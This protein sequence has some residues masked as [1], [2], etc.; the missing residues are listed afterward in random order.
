MRSEK[1]SI[2]GSELINEHEVAK[3]AKLS[4]L[5]IEMFVTTGALKVYGRELVDDADTANVGVKLE[6]KLFNKKDVASLF[7]IEIVE[8]EKSEESKDNL[9]H[10]PVEEE[11]VSAEEAQSYSYLGV[12]RSQDTLLN[13]KFEEIND[14]REQR[15]WL[16][17]R[18]EKLEEQL[19][20]ERLIVLAETQNIGQALRNQVAAAPVRSPGLFQQLLMTL[21]LTDRGGKE[22]KLLE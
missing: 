3:L 6:L 12:I 9:V 20:Q 8:E 5:T 18:V 13:L 11:D 2:D 14:L 1:V 17:R 7:G 10:F 15:E 16:K 21:G 19:D 4:L 22:Q